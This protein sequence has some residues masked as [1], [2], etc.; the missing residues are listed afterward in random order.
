MG[1]FDRYNGKSKATNRLSGL[2]KSEKNNG[3]PIYGV[4]EALNLAGS[5]SNESYRESALRAIAG[6]LAKAGEPYK[7]LF[8]KA[9]QTVRW[10]GSLHRLPK[11][12][13]TSLTLFVKLG[14]LHRVP[15]RTSRYPV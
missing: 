15:F 6:E 11:R 13:I 8:D 2:I 4:D 5:I 7:P 12:L 3:D 1:S 9:L 10:K 14:S